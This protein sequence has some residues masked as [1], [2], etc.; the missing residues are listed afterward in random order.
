MWLQLV[1]CAASLHQPKDLGPTL[2]TLIDGQVPKSKA[3]EADLT[4]LSYRLPDAMP[5][6]G[7]FVVDTSNLFAAL[8]GE[9]LTNRRSLDRV[10]KHL[11]VPTEYLHNAGNDTLTWLN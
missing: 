6:E 1:H 5:D 10:C 3:I 11:Q 9:G 4:G 7:I 8:E 2:P